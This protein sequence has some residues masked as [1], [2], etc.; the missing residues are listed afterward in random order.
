MK[1]RPR[2]IPHV[3]IE[4]AIDKQ[5]DE[6]LR[7]DDDHGAKGDTHRDGHTRQ[8]TVE[9]ADHGKASPA[10]EDH[11]GMRIAAPDHL[12]K[13]VAKPPDGERDRYVADRPPLAR[14]TGSDRK[15]ASSQAGS[16]L[17]TFRFTSS[18]RYC[19]ADESPP[20]SSIR[21]RATASLPS[22]IA[23]TSVASSSVR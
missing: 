14:A 17:F 6:K 1:P 18:L 9:K 7:K 11:G 22:M 20:I 12:Q 10:R 4:H 13:P 2:V 23:P 8:L 19:I 3:H 15:T 16:S 21:P 5:P